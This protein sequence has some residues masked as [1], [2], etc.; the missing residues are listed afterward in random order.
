MDEFA[1]TIKKEA[2][3]AMR[4]IFRRDVE[5]KTD[6]I[7]ELITS[8]LE[9]G[10][11][12]V[13]VVGNAPATTDQWHTWN[14]LVLEQPEVVTRMLS[15]ELERERPALPSEPEVMR[16]WAARLLLATLG[17]LGML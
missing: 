1:N 10:A 14:R 12:G 2:A 11:G 3:E 6:P 16:A 5:P 15:R 9:D 4:R 17:R 8:L 13:V 7:L